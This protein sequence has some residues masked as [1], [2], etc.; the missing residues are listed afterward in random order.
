MGVRNVKYEMLIRCSVKKTV[1]YM[2]VEFRGEVWNIYL[3]FQ[4]RIVL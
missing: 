3:G 2:Y 4:S 1:V